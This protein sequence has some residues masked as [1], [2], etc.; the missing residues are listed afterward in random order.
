[1]KRRDFLK[2]AGLA[3][4]ASAFAFSTAVPFG[5]NTRQAEAWL[6]HGGG[7]DLLNELYAQYNCYGIPAGNTTAQMGGW[8]RKELNTVDDF[9]GIKMRI[10]GFAGKVIGKL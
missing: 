2:S 6:M 3:T 4:A 5:P 10:G 8:F 9:K 1:M 7:A